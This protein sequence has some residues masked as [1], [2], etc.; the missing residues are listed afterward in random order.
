VGNHF[1]TVVDTEATAE[2][3]PGLAARVI[4][5]LVAEGIITAE[6][7]CLVYSGPDGAGDHG[8]GVGE[9]WQKAVHGEGWD[10][11]GG[12]AVLVGR[13]LFFAGQG[14]A[15]ASGAT[16]PRCEGTVTFID[17]PES[18][19]PDEALWAPFREALNAWKAGGAGDV[20]CPSCAAVSPVTLW[21]WDDQEI[22]LG[23][24]AFDFWGWPPL[25]DAFVASVGELLGHKVALIVGKL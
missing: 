23:S 22:A 21:R 4:E 6:R 10:P 24:L 12:L 11:A 25:D 7:D 14:S 5:K 9:H 8:H 17:Y 18:F 1:Q 13:E 19:E 2:E 3:A 15:D 20:A 16:C